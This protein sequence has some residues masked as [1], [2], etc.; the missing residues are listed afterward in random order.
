MQQQERRAKR[1]FPLRLP[2][3]I[4]G[5]PAGSKVWAVT[6]DVSAQGVFFYLDDW[7]S[8]VST[9]AF[10][11][12]LPA[13]LLGGEESMTAVCKGKIVRLEKHPQMKTGV[14]STIDEYVFTDSEKP[15][16]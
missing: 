1:R 6:R 14:A 5:T 2:I 12:I 13:E 4:T 15:V 10:N 16:C 3:A 9:I 7:P 11:I 8:G